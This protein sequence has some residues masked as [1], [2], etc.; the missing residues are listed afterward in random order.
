L[1]FKPCLELAGRTL[2]DVFANG[3]LPAGLLHLTMDRQQVQSVVI[4]EV[5]VGGCCWLL[6]IKL[7][8]MCCSVLLV[9]SGTDRMKRRG[10]VRAPASDIADRYVLLLDPLVGTGRTACEDAVGRGAEALPSHMQ[11]LILFYLHGVICHGWAAAGI[12][13]G[14]AHG[15]HSQHVGSLRA[16]WSQEMCAT[17]H[18]WP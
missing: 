3:A 6:V 11:L 14:L 8:C 10:G 7:H 5:H 1:F 13:T 9:T 12:A 4:Q 18:E 2:I 17:W 15:L 16:G